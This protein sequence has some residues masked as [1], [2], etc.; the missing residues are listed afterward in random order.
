MIWTS[1]PRLLGGRLLMFW[2]SWRFS[3][4]VI[5]LVSSFERAGVTKNGS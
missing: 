2:L 5:S 4:G 3:S 1:S